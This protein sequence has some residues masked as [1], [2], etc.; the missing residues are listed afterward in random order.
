MDI[1]CGLEQKQI[2]NCAVFQSIFGLAKNIWTR[3]KHF[4]TCRR[5]RHKPLNAGI[6]SEIAGFCII[7]KF[8]NPLHKPQKAFYGH[9]TTS[10]LQL[11]V[12]VF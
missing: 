8:L 3:Q 2:G 6:S 12:Q 1:I 4:G 9:L 7:V 11:I 10:Y 5:M